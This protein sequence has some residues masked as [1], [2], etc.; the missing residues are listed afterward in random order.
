MTP[1]KP[2]KHLSPNDP[3]R[4]ILDTIQLDDDDD[5]DDNLI[6]NL[7]IESIVNSQKK[8]K[9]ND[10]LSDSTDEYENNE[11]LNSKKRKLNK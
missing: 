5:D 1:P 11:N 4:K 10:N 3:K 8:I 9:E 7:N 2:I 6:N